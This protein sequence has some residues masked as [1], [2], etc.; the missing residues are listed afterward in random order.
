METGDWLTQ[1]EG[2]A[3]AGRER[4]RDAWMLPHDAASGGR[5]ASI[6][7]HRLAC[8][9]CCAPSRPLACRQVGERLRATGGVSVHAVP[10]E[11]GGGDAV[12][13][14]TNSWT[15]QLTDNM[16]ASVRERERERGR[17]EWDRLRAEG[18]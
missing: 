10:G 16:N 15:Y 2:V 6:G 12:L 17:R 5:R 14:L 11:R 9:S 3:R 8:P 18:R 4:E 1:E 13:A 7:C